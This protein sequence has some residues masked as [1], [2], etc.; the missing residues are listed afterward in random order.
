MKSVSAALRWKKRC[1]K[2]IWSCK[3]Q[4]IH[5]NSPFGKFEIGSHVL[6]TN[7]AYT[8]TYRSRRERKQ[9]RSYTGTVSDHLR[10]NALCVGAIVWG[11]DFDFNF[12]FDRSPFSWIHS[13]LTLP[14]NFVYVC[15]WWTKRL[16]CWFLFSFIRS[17]KFSI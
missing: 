13:W 17:F 1:R 9:G 7:H 3:Q 4:I 2:T 8:I 10:P 5:S 14:S 11:S 16:H 6:Y 12:D 15:F